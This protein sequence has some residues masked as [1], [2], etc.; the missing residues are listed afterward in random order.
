MNDD[1]TKGCLFGAG[2]VGR[3]YQET[4]RDDEEEKDDDINTI[5]VIE[6]II[7]GKEELVRIMAVMG[8]EFETNQ[9]SVRCIESRIAYYF[10]Y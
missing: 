1:L 6:M 3:N 7:F 9:T 10:Y 4:G 8:T 5:I 2:K